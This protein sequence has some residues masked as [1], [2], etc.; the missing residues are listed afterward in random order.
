MERVHVDAVKLL[1]ELRLSVETTYM[2]PNE[3]QR[4][5]MLLIDEGDDDV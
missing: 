1:C 5:T 3:T 2:G 4:V